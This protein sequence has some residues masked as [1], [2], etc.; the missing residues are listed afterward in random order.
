MPCDRV[1]RESLPASCKCRVQSGFPEAYQRSIPVIGIPH[2][3]SILRAGDNKSLDAL[4]V[5]LD[6]FREQLAILIPEEGLTVTE[7]VEEELDYRVIKTL[8]EYEAL[9]DEIEDTCEDNLI[10]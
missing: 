2:P 10:S 5:N 1:C 7:R 8:D 9:A 3:H 6:F 4:D